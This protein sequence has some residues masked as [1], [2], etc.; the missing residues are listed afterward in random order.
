MELK[1]ISR[2]VVIAG[3][4]VIWTIKFLIRPAQLVTPPFDFFLG[5]APNFLGSF[6]IPFCACWFFSGR[7]FKLS[8][9]F[10][11]NTISALRQLCLTAFGMLLINE[12]LQKIPFFG[13][14]FDFFDILFSAIG[15]TVSYFVF[16]RLQ[17]RYSISRVV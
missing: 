2:R 10:Q 9:L 15:L 3:T 13:R 4:L 11:V 17:Q 16:S 5:I 14:T 12:Y 6:L 8:Q 7:Y 1:Y